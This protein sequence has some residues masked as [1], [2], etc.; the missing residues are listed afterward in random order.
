MRRPQDRQ[1][2]RWGGCFRIFAVW[3]AITH[4]TAAGDASAAISAWQR[5]KVAPGADFP[6]AD[7]EPQKQTPQDPLNAV[8]ERANALVQATR[9]AEAQRTLEDAARSHSDPGSKA[10]LWAAASG[11]QVAWARD[12]KQKGAPEEAIRH[13]LAAFEIDKVY[14]PQAAGPD[15]NY[16]GVVCN[17]SGASTQAIGFFNQAL[18]WDRRT[19][20]R[21]AA[22]QSLDNLG[23][24][25][26]NLSQ[27][28]KA[29]ACFN[30]ALPIRREV[31]DRRG[32]GVTLSG[33]A[34]TY[35]DL[36]QYRRAIEYYDQALIAL[37]ASG[38]RSEQAT[39]RAGL[40]GAYVLLGN[41]EKAIGE[42][43]GA[44][45]IAR[46]TNNRRTEASILNNLGD[47]YG[48]VGQYDKANQVF[49]RALEIDRE[50]RNRAGES[51]TLDNLGSLAMDL[52]RP[53]EAAKDYES[54]LNIARELGDRSGEAGALGNLGVAY[55]ALRQFDRAAPCLE[56]ALKMAHEFGNRAAEASIL[57]NLSG[58]YDELGQ[59]G[60]AL[61]TRRRAVAI[62]RELGDRAGESAAL[63]NLG[64]LYSANQDFARALACHQ[65]ALGLAR[66]TGNVRAEAGA[67]ASLMTDYR[68]L[69]K[70]RQ[71]ILYG[72]LSIAAWEKI[73][74]ST[75]ALDPASRKSFVQSQADIYREL[76]DLLVSQGR[77]S[78][79]QQILGLLKQEE[80]TEYIGRGPA[81]AAQPVAPGLTQNESLWAERYEQGAGQVSAAAARRQELRGRSSL[82]PAETQE[83]KRLDSQGELIMVAFQK[84]LDELDKEA[85]QAP[86][87]AG[88]VEELRES[89]GLMQ[90]LPDLGSS[91]VAVCTLVGESKLHLILITPDLIVA[92]EY[93]IGRAE[94]EKKVVRFRR[95]LQDPDS[96]PLP[97][98][99]DLYK[100]LIGPIEKDLDDAKATTLMWSLDGMLRYL[101]IAALHDGQHFLVERYRNVEFTLASRTRLK[102]RPNA[103]W[104]V[105]GLGVSK[106]EPGFA[107][108]PAVSQELRAIVR[109][110][111]G[112]TGV[113]PG[114]TLLD[115]AFTQDRFQDLLS[116]NYPVVHIASH[117][118]LEPGD[119]AA[120]FLLLGDGSHL[121]LARLALIPNLFA[122]VDLLTLSACNTG[123]GGAR[124]DGREVESLGVLA[125]RKGAKA[126]VATL[127]PV[128]DE[129]TRLLVQEFYRLHTVQPGVSKAEALQR[130]QLALLGKVPNSGG[131]RASEFSHPFY[132]A[133]FI[134]IGNGK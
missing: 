91:V 16:A 61:E 58:V 68:L 116:L 63:D 86:R 34:N 118:E 73:R 13:Y 22:G 129:S 53:D 4:T 46:E 96:D 130:A 30:Q 60:E 83:L 3:L 37:E 48:R 1:G 132:W 57:N 64:S 108:L 9:F 114:L 127:W 84:T 93:P 40:G 59:R 31:Q 85:E 99:H 21:L 117:F 72:K 134:L 126:I 26:R 75:K 120:S 80:Y 8:L 14:R 2:I 65:R 42:L 101:P 66:E 110:E 43:E 19:G 92:R 32:E 36:G 106:A 5:G 29:I 109:D 95:N 20:N 11:V 104:K 100:I 102:E 123:M 7:Q 78:E 113:L 111:G 71:A 131:Q 128:A 105:L 87:S 17:L 119:A 115:D 52:G 54:S 125:Q 133:P 81:E 51:A 98:A 24:A 49:Q 112:Q 124:A 70:P 88:K 50:T 79:G 38:D 103:A 69:A 41:Y 77:V 15:L 107:A 45:V 23:Q 76:A 6:L 44:L 27:F 56:Q 122:N 12:M 10:Q 97:D 35:M 18:D 82:T 74:G 39:T 25:Y 121:T 90:D 89:E 33:L 94:L 55:V 28:E 62:C 67:L 47:A